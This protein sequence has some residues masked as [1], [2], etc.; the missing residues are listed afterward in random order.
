MTDYDIF[1]EKIAE[2]GSIAYPTGAEYDMLSGGLSCFALFPECSSVSL[3]VL[4]EHTFEFGFKL[5]MPF[6][7]EEKSRQ[8]FPVLVELGMIARVVNENIAVQSEV[9]LQSD[10]LHVVVVPLYANSV[11]GI[12]VLTRAR[13]A[14]IHPTRMTELKILGQIFGQRIA[15]FRLELAHSQLQHTHK[16]VIDQVTR[17]HS[18][19]SERE[20]LLE[21]L[22]VGVAIVRKSDDTITYLNPMAK[23]FIGIGEE[24]LWLESSARYFQPVHRTDEQII[25]DK[26]A[27]LTTREGRQVPILLLD[28]EMAMEQT[29]YR[30]LCFA[31]ITDRKY[32]E[33]E[34]RRVWSDLEQSLTD[35]TDQLLGTINK[36]AEEADKRKKAEEDLLKF[37]WAVQQS[38][39]GIML[40]NVEGIVE[41]VNPQF[42]E[43][44]GYSFSQ[45][46]GEHSRVLR[47]SLDAQ[48]E[49]EKVIATIKS[50]SIWQG[51]HSNRKRDGK[52]YWVESIVSPIF[53]ATGDITHFV[54][55]QVDVTQKKMAE[56]ELLLAKERA[57]S[58][59]KLKGSIIANMSHEFRTPLIS[60][61]GYTQLLLEDMKDPE[62]LDWLFK[63]HISG[64]R[65]LQTLNSVL[66]L[67]QIDAI[68]MYSSDEECAFEE[69]VGAMVDKIHKK[70]ED[71]NVRLNYEARL[72]E[73]VV[74]APA[75]MLEMLAV[76]IID[77]AVKFTSAG[78]ISIVLQ[79]EKND[80]GEENLLF[81]VKDSGIGIAEE[82]LNTIFQP[83][84]QQS[85]GFN[86]SFEGAGLGLTIVQK[87]TELLQGKIEVASTL[88]KGTTISVRLPLRKKQG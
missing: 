68:S 81:E 3:F 66:F 6:P 75:E 31:D 1:I 49:Y 55:M 70:A 54:S 18:N 65:L 23:A 78:D 71:K 40:T 46:V 34:L 20:F 26:E 21:N 52:V 25:A 2:Y 87:I 5:S 82:A 56:K 10:P 16:E 14:V 51:E 85:E 53:N 88:N 43:V 84:R 45:I 9:L 79:T 30:I 73:A 63:I 33:H 80:A 74:R 60:I 77:N 22:P 83:F 35:R 76:Q 13:D 11:I 72:K 37:Y 17:L 28:N 44:S 24:Y 4:D 59:D 67:A 8:L 7:S 62:V 61:L 38:P 15:G 36:L 27:L 42:C 69:I 58:A 48:G 12:V 47:S 39:V 41:F 32:R 64:D 57:E 50:G 19:S 29:E 86:R